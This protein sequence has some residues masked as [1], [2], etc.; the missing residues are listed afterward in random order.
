MSEWK[1]IETAPKDRTRILV[2]DGFY[3]DTAY[4]NKGEW[5]HYECG[6]DWYSMSCN[7]SF[8]M[9]LPDAPTNSKEGI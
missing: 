6:D 7:P 5:W 9:P 4:F 3:V 2:S 1:P 8:W